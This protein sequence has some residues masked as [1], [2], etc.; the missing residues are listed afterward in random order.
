MT[1]G[2]A[3]FDIIVLLLAAKVAAEIS[4][5]IGIPAV[6]GEILAG[7]AIGPSL[8]ALVS[9]SDVIDVLGELGVILLLV[10]VGMQIDL[11]ELAKVG[12]AALLVATIGVAL[13]FVGGYLA[14][15][16]LGLPDDSALFVGAA[17]TATSVGIT[18]RVFGELGALSS[19]EA[20][21]VLGAAVA[22]D[23]IGLLI[24]ALVTSSV[25]GE[26]ISV[27]AVAD[28][29]ATAVVV[30]VGSALGGVWLAPR[31]LEQLQRW[32]QTPGTLVAM[33]LVF[34]LAFG[35]IADFAGLTPVIGAFVAGIALARSTI[36]DRIHREL[37]PVGHLLV[38]V[39]F[40]QIGVQSRVEELASAG[41]I[42]LALVLLAV[43]IAGKL[44]S[45]IGAFA[46][47]GDKLTIG[48]GMLPRGE[49]GLIFATV[50]LQLGVVDQEIY[51]ALLVVV[52]VTTLISPFLLR[53]RMRAAGTTRASGIQ[54]AAATPPVVQDGR[55]LVIHD[56][57]VDLNRDAPA[58]L[59]L[60]LG[61]EAALAVASGNAPGTR[62]MEWL[63]SL[64]GIALQWDERASQ[65]F[66]Q[67][68][69]EGNERSWRLLETSRLL[70]R[71][72][73]E[74]AREICMH[75]AD[76]LELDPTV[77]FRWSVLDRLHD[78]VNEDSRAARV[79]RELDRTEP[80]YVAAL[81]LSMTGEGPNAIKLG[82]RLANRL[83]LG[84]SMEQ[85]IVVL[86]KEADLLYS[87]TKRSD[88]LD[89]EMVLRVADRLRSRR[90]TGCV[91][92]ISLSLEEL[93]DADRQRMDAL[94]SVV[95]SVLT[96]ETITS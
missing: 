72:L 2:N 58:A 52:L 40:L 67:L 91:Y 35:M 47:R 6:V 33:S 48:L 43:A 37:A 16:W 61:L 14:G 30:L 24:L 5:R 49:V 82:R 7:I 12:R 63:G 71:T 28:D 81:V 32:A 92:L 11:V 18:A 26:S 78:V 54:R 94:F 64:P 87:A 13:P 8:L 10:E 60:H 75:G 38:P 89:Q 53:W 21:T 4:Q 29:L 90:V 34:I 69:R 23:V 44:V 22:D 73:P 85:E 1:M 84:A 95:S 83:A 46:S 77:P 57:I 19:P 68:L 56:G 55:D 88:F 20:R 9:G 65:I 3:L 17:L 27:G 45:G 36:S 74:V 86:V 79:A 62:Q 80:L 93:I 76:P 51:G 42:Q 25:K 41:S 96:H 50:G 59:G 66:C 31:A 70:E 39:F 15:I